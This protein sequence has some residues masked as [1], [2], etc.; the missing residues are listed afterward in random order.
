[1]MFDGSSELIKPRFTSRYLELIG[2]GIFLSSS[3]LDLGLR[4]HY[5]PMLARR[6]VRILGF[7]MP[8]IWPAALPKARLSQL[9][10]IAR[11]LVT[12]SV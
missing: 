11:N 1:M 3:Q 6:K 10:H 7:A 2:V 12:D 8:N 5:V 9:S 4:Q